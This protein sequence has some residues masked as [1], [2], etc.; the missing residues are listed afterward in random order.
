MAKWQRLLGYSLL[1]PSTISTMLISFLLIRK[2]SFLSSIDLN[3]V[4]EVEAL[5]MYFGLM[6]I[7]GTLLLIRRE[8]NTKNS[9]SSSSH[10]G[11]P[12][13]KLISAI[14]I[15]VTC[16]I[17]IIARIAWPSIKIDDK[18]IY[19]FLI[20]AGPWLTL[21]FDNIK[22]GDKEI[23]FRDSDRKEGST[24]KKI[25]PLVNVNFQAIDADVISTEATRVLATLAIYQA[26]HFGTDPSNRW[27]FAV[28]PT[29]SVYPQYL[30]GVSELV[31]LGLVAVNP[32]DYQVLLTNIGLQYTEAHPQIRNH[33]D[34]YMF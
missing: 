17:A 19:L 15:G 5:L 26:K 25:S 9:S 10:D 18:T 24:T 1:V 31:S 7:I 27:T 32:K 23:S 20:G 4:L 12:R 21:F 13:I 16:A 34:V 22:W 6:A 30:K 11:W 14:T 8:Q 33:T 3:S 29:A 28:S 2:V